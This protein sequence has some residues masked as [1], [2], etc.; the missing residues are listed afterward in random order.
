MPRNNLDDLLNGI[1][2]TP[3]QEPIQDEIPEAVNDDLSYGESDNLEPEQQQELQQDPLDEDHDH[4]ELD[5]QPKHYDDYGNEIPAPRMYSEE[6][7]DELI[8]KAVRERLARLKMPA[9]QATYEPE[10]YQQPNQYQQP[11]QPPM[12]P[13]QTQAYAQGFQYNESS[14]VPF[15]V[16]LNYYID[17]RIDLATKNKEREADRTQK[18]LLKQQ[19]EQ[20]NQEFVEKVHAG[21]G[22]FSDFQQTVSVQPF[23]EDMLRGVRSF[24]DPAAF[25]YAASK[26]QSAELQRIAQIQDPYAQIVEIGK[27]EE[28]M[29]KNKPTTQAPRPI[30]RTTGNAS[31]PAP[32]QQQKKPSIDDLLMASDAKRLQDR[33]D[34]L[35]R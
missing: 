20:A 26:Q 8:N 25:I 16:Q 15:D 27:L 4:D 24:K 28:R 22:R 33:R 7:K 14:E 19:E 13:Q 35:R 34:R 18:M 29:R 10:G 3:E 23:T 31:A 32:K 1:P 21:M 30:Q 12:T 9:Q 5:Q 2:S 11:Y 6:E 17:S